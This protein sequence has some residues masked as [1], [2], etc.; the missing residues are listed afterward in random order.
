MDFG[1][2]AYK[3]IFLIVKFRIK[4]YILYCT[5]WKTILNLG[6]SFELYNS[7]YVYNIVIFHGW[8]VL[9]LV[10]LLHLLFCVIKICLGFPFLDTSVIRNLSQYYKL[11]KISHILNAIDT[12]LLS[13]NRR[14]V[15]I[16]FFLTIDAPWLSSSSSQ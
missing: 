9:V 7:Y 3:I 4:F 1:L 2:C 15:T 6:I 8:W 11:F 16:F 5:I 14:S 12:L 13:H 10:L